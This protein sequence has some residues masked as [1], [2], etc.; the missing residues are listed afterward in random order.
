MIHWCTPPV[1]R[2][3]SEKLSKGLGKEKLPGSYNNCQ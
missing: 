2:Q 1:E 3:L